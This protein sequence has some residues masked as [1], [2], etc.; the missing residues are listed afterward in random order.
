MKL[1]VAYHC[2]VCQEI[3]E[4]APHDRC[5]RC[6]SHGVAALFWLVKSA[7]ERE[8]WFDR[9]RGGVRR[10]QERASRS[11]FRYSCPATVNRIEPKAA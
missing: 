7:A 11:A 5:P 9:I 3:F 2:H 4:R 10:V 1:L 8:A 6:A